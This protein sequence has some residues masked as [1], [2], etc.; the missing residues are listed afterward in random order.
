MLRRHPVLLFFLLACGFS[1][2]GF[3][4][5]RLSLAGLLPFQLPAEFPLVAE[6]GPT[7]AALFLCFR[8]GGW[9][10]VKRLL[11]R[12]VRWRVHWAWYLVVLFGDAV[13]LAALIG[14]RQLLGYPVPDVG[15]L[16]GWDTRFI[17]HM[18]ELGPSIGPVGGL[19][20]AMERSSL[21]TILG[22]AVVAIMSGGVTEEFGWRGYA[23]PRLS[24]RWSALKASVA[25]GVLWA[26]WHL[27]PWHLFFTEPPGVAARENL[28]FLGLYLYGCIP[29]AVLFGWVYYNT[30]GSVLLAILYHAAHNTVVSVAFRSW[31]EFPFHWWLGAQT[32]AAVLVTLFYGPARL[33]R[34][35]PPAP[36][37]KPIDSDTI[38]S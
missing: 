4:L 31:E 7:L 32:V 15:Q 11:A 26:I 35:R 28:L 23:Q 5:H 36:D 20:W 3:F 38:P 21:A 34:G 22:A 9:P 24:D 27:G 16:G 17:T 37:G 6:Y 1:W 14:F 2:P 25:I 30:R 29:L 19:V 10:P 13:I 18:K 8:E 33:V 12:G